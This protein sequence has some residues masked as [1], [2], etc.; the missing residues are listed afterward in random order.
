MS[1]VSFPSMSAGPGRTVPRPRNFGRC[2]DL[3]QSLLLAARVRLLW[4]HTAPL[5]Q[6][7]LQDR[8]ALAKRRSVIVTEKRGPPVALSVGK[9]HV[10]SAVRDRHIT[11]PIRPIDIVCL[12]D[13]A[14]IE[15]ANEIR[16][17][18]VVSTTVLGDKAPSKP[19]CRPFEGL[20]NRGSSTNPLR[21]WFIFAILPF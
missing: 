6:L 13:H 10:V 19:T 14:V 1:F 4:P 15:A 2:Y 16:T 12:G 20:S 11:G 18:Q 8:R 3:R 7:D 9:E 17:D 5:V 21:S